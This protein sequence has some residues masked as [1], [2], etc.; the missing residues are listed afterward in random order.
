MDNVS[1]ILLGC[2]LVIQS[3]TWVTGTNPACAIGPPI[4]PPNAY[5]APSTITELTVNA[6]HNVLNAFEVAIHWSVDQYV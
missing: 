5:I 6:L 2:S 1:A 4:L 3:T